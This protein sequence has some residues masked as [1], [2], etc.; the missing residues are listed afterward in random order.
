MNIADTLRSQGLATALTTDV[1]TVTING[2]KCA[3]IVNRDPRSFEMMDA[4]Y[5]DKEPV[6]IEVEK[7]SSIST[8]T[9][10]LDAAFVPADL[11][12][13][14]PNSR[15]RVILGTAPG[16]CIVDSVTNAGSAW[17]ISTLKAT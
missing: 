7:G 14:V 1:E 4:G 13:Y 10:Y 3:A 17:V 6:T 8:R 2:R 12:G 15:D 9:M 16:F 5:S 11:R